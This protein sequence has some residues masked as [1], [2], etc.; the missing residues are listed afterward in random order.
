[1]DTTEYGL[2]QQ[3]AEKFRVRF[4]AGMLPNDG[5]QIGRDNAVKVLGDNIA[6]M[7][8]DVG[9]LKHASSDGK[10]GFNGFR[11]QGFQFLRA[12]SERT[13][14]TRPAER[15]HGYNPFIKCA[16]NP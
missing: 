14:R 10:V 13:R 8:A 16:A 6:Q 4:L 15:C 1:M 3:I 11:N 5:L 7:F 2:V 12:L 9:F